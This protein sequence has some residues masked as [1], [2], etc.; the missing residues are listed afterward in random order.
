MIMI[1]QLWPKVFVIWI[2]RKGGVRQQKNKQKRKQ[3]ISHGTYS[4]S[5]APSTFAWFCELLWN[6]Q[7]KP[8]PSNVHE[9]KALNDV[10]LLNRSN[11]FLTSNDTIT[12]RISIERCSND[13]W[14]HIVNMWCA[15][16]DVVEL[17][18][19]INISSLG[20]MLTSVSWNEMK[21]KLFCY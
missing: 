17:Q 5:K 12:T 9:A 15:S 19:A 2:R 6:K 3:W 18:M 20:H 13:N 7:I 11:I 16:Y 14:S 4:P 8:N 1:L 10:F 21:W